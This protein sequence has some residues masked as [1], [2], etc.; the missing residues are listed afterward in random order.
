MIYPLGFGEA[1]WRVA[2]VTRFAVS[3]CSDHAMEGVP[4][5]KVWIIRRLA[6]EQVGTLLSP[7]EIMNITSYTLQTLRMPAR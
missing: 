6:T 1:K 7:P 5:A 2:E 3:P 4:T